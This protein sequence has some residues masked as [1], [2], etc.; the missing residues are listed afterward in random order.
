MFKPLEKK[1]KNTIGSKK[2]GLFPWW[3]TF[4]KQNFDLKQ[5]YDLL[6]VRTKTN[7]LL[8]SPPSSTSSVE[9]E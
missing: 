6:L 7:N 4:Y 9:I 3:S 2:E 1:K 5:Q 8:S